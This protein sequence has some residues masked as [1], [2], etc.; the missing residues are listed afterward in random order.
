MYESRMT[1]QKERVALGA[2]I[3]AGSWNR[4]H[5]Q[6]GCFLYL[7]ASEHVKKDDDEDY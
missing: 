2:H 7:I 5:G 3:S 4:S 6:A 1:R